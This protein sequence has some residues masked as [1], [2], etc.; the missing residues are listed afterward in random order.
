MSKKEKL[1]KIRLE[2]LSLFSTNP[3]NEAIEKDGFIFFKHWD[4]NYK[5]WTVSKFT[6]ESWFNMK[7]R[8][9]GQEKK[10]NDYIEMEKA[11]KEL[12]NNY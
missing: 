10:D 11:S 8:S 2:R 3:Q 1:N 9:Y 6:K 12:E 7:G 4:G 5:R